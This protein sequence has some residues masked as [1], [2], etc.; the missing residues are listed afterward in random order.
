[1]VRILSLPAA[2]QVR[3]CLSR[4]FA[5]LTTCVACAVGYR[6]PIIPA[7]HA[8]MERITCRPAYRAGLAANA[9][10]TASP[11]QL[12]AFSFARRRGAGRSVCSGRCR[13]SFALGPGRTW[14]CFGKSGS[15]HSEHTMTGSKSL[16]QRS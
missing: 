1:M 9:P 13:G 10:R 6:V 5:L 4:G 12:A 7:C 16:P 2:S 15:P 14:T 3:T 8:Y 11:P